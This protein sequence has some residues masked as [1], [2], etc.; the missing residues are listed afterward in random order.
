MPKK[1]PYGLCHK[2]QSLVEIPGLDAFL[3]SQCG[4]VPEPLK[5]P[6]TAQDT[7]TTPPKEIWFTRK[8]EPTLLDLI[9]S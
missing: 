7:E 5:R 1:A 9:D 2:C 8:P 4:W 3:C 6:K